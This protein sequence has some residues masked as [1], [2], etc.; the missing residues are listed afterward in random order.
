M[1]LFLSIF[2][3]CALALAAPP[4]NAI[5]SSSDQLSKSRF[6]R[7]LA[8]IKAKIG[9]KTISKQSSTSNDDPNA[10]GN[11][12]LSDLPD[13]V[14]PEIIKFLSIRDKVHLERASKAMLG[15]V[16]TT[17]PM[18]SPE[19]PSRQNLESFFGKA[20]FHNVLRH[21]YGL[22]NSAE[23]YFKR[24]DSYPLM[25]AAFCADSDVSRPLTLNVKHR[26]SLDEIPDY[27]L[28][29]PLL[30]ERQ[31]FKKCG[32]V[33]FKVEVEIDERTLPDDMAELI[34]LQRYGMIKKLTVRRIPDPIIE[35]VSSLLAR[36]KIEHVYCSEVT[37]AST[38]C[39]G[40]STGV[41]RRRS[42]R[43]LYHF[44]SLGEQRF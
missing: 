36:G 26:L 28:V 31:R 20:S 1:N 32:H 44:K 35:P 4:N 38:R 34:Q 25:F 29:K 22:D 19:T 10:V 23:W 17:R 42:S 24:Y 30:E 27:G 40:L 2:F 39:R 18:L 5:E 14:L 21:L 16:R 41:R 8:R 3:L 15:A 13:H 9:R 7:F 33:P 37:V 12:P 6:S 43:R 11:G